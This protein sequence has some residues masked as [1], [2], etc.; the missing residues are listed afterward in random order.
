MVLN[1]LDTEVGV[2]YVYGF[3][4]VTAAHSYMLSTK[5]T[6]LKHKTFVKR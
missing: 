2:D 5:K 3:K 4:L 1:P 6:T